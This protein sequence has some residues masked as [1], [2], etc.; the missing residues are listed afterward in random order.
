MSMVGITIISTM[1][2]FLTHKYNLS[3]NVRIALVLADTQPVL[4]FPAIL[5][6]I[7]FSGRVVAVSL[8]ST[9]SSKTLW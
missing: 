6:V 3:V 9:R 1:K 8:T 5:I 2:M 7:I 4:Q